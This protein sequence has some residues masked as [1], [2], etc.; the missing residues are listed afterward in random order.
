ME[1]TLPKT[2]R[3]VVDTKGNKTDVMMPLATLDE[4]LE[5]AYDAGVAR[6]RLDDDDVPWR[7]AVKI[8]RHNGKV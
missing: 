2:A 4:L 5:D 6:S 8:L 3:F 1:I 7:E